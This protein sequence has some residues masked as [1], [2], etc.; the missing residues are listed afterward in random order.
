MNRLP[1]RTPLVPFAD[2]STARVNDRQHSPWFKSLN[3]T[4]KIKRFEDVSQVTAASL[5]SDT[6]K[7]SKISVPGN[8][9]LA[10]LGDLPH[11]TNVQMPWQGRPPSLPPTVATAVHRT[12]FSIA[13][14]WKKRRTILHIGGAE[15]VHMV[16]LNGEFLGYGTDSRLPSEYD[17]SDALVSGKNDLAIVVCRFSAQ[18]HLEDQDQWW[19]AGLHREVFLRSQAQIALND[20]HVN[21]GVLKNG[22]GTL[23]IDVK[24]SVPAGAM[25]QC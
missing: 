10:G 25:L 3:D 15:S 2:V 19:M 14:P 12:T 23:D 9:T 16:Y 18:S 1:M 5:T 4:W 11:Y 8:W 6:G 17:V 7:W 24:V 22:T 21:A 13:A 20:A